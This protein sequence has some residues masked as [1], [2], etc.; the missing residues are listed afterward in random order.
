MSRLP[1]CG[2]RGKSAD[3]FCADAGF[4]FI[5]SLTQGERFLLLLPRVNLNVSGISADCLE[6]S[7]TALQYSKL[8][9]WPFSLLSASVLPACDH[10]S[11]QRNTM[12]FRNINHTCVALTDLLIVVFICTVILATYFFQYLSRTEACSFAC[13]K[14]PL[15]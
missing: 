14:S 7:V 6:L 15:P 13:R 2:S 11:S 10:H 9:F 5:P 4:F 1:R 8:S 3:L 12:G